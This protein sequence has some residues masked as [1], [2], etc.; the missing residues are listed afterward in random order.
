VE[1]KNRLKNAIAGFKK[2]NSQGT[3][4]NHF[5]KYGSRRMNSSWS[6]PNITDEDFYTGYGFAVINKRANRSVSLGK[7]FLFTEAKEEIVKKANDD[8]TRVVHPY[9]DLIRNSIDFSERDFWYNIST[10]LDLEGVYYLMAVRTV[11]TGGKVGNIQKF[12]MLNPYWVKPVVNSKGILGGYAESNPH[13][14]NRVIAKEMIIPITLLNPF[15][16][17]KTYSLADASRDSQFT[18]K[19]ANDFARESIDGNLNAPGILS[20]AIEL[21]DDQFENFVNR[22]KNHGRGEPLFGNGSGTIS[23]TDMQTDLDK[24]ALDKINSINR[25]VLLAVAGTSKTGVGV[26]ESGTGREVSRTQKDDFTENAVMPQIE[27]II[28][29]LNLDYRRFYDT[30]YKKNNYIIALNNP[31]ETNKDA[32]QADVDI[33]DSQFVLLQALIARGYS[34]DVASKYAKGLIDITD[35]GEPT[36]VVEPPVLP[37]DTTPTAEVTPVT[38]VVEPNQYKDKSFDIYEGYPIPVNQYLGEHAEQFNAISENGSFI[39]STE[40]VKKVTIDHLKEVDNALIAIVDDNTFIK[41]GNFEQ[42]AD[43]AAIIAKLNKRY[44]NQPVAVKKKINLD[45]HHDVPEI[46]KNASFDKQAQIDSSTAQLESSSR[47]A[48][49]KLYEWYVNQINEGVDSPQLTNLEQFI[50]SL[51]LPFAVYFTVM[52]PIYA[53]FRVRQTADDLGITD[54]VPVVALTTEVKDTIDQF[55]RRDATSHINTI[56]TDIEN[57]IATIRSSSPTPEEFRQQFQQLFQEIQQRRSLTIAS[58]AATRI[59][60]ISQYEA[61]LQFLTRA[62]LVKKAYK[63]LFSLT[64]APCSFCSSVIA[65]TNASPIPFTTAF[66]NMGDV[67]EADDKKLSINFEN[68]MAGSVHTNCNCAYRLIVKDDVTESS[69]RSGAITVDNSQVAI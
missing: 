68:I 37:D 48:Q 12:T 60:N 18:L 34:I 14:G 30:E 44:T 41:L 32:E 11:V 43:R 65:E 66:A 28:D 27:N 47:A 39:Y 1:I 46:I 69:S 9:L 10:Y 64:G 21:P 62:G 24:A 4:P 54:Q 33:R 35:L 67:I 13:L 61:D 26:E 22:I 31:L 50:N 15:D 59:F 40:E 56:R 63:V 58:N 29:S 25:D 8:G 7:K 19:Q 17:T 42:G 3:D 20:S 45:H 53:S 16:E 49:N 57:A 36:E 38:P 52:F 2:I 51:T 5:L 23:W 55:A 6:T